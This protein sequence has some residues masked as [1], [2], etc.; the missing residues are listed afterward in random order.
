MRGTATS[1]L[2]ALAVA[3]VTAVS[4]APAQ[5]APVRGVLLATQSTATVRIDPATGQEL[6]TVG[7]GAGAAVSRSGRLAYSRDVDPCHP[8]VEGCF[9]APDLLTARR[10]GSRERVIVH[11]PEAGGGVA[12][13][14]WSPDGTKLVYLWLTPGE[15]GLNL[16]NANGTGNEQLVS[17]AGP[18][19]F[20]PDGRSVAFVKDSDVHVIDLETREIR[21]VTAEGL[22]AM[23]APDWSPD[24]QV[25]VY[26]GQ[27][28]FLTVP[29]AGG[30]SV[31]AGQWPNL[32]DQVTAPVFSPN[33]RWVAFTATESSTN[34][35]E[36][37]VSRLFVAAVDGSR[38]TAVTD[39]YAQLTDWIRR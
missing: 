39:T 25:I 20:S 13:P 35:E 33:G 15:R 2:C 7:A 11:N 6:G 23:S 29:A 34:P 31:H 14:D 22:A 30:A 24:G 18:G 26:A 16:V 4:G 12:L 8:D 19:T 36:P 37:A 32:L 9:G 17:F 21:A 1:V 28:E 3:G 27:T 38:L 5:A 10:D